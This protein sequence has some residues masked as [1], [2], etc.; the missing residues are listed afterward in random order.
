MNSPIDDIAFLARSE[1]RVRILRAIDECPRDRRA[2]ATVTDT[3]KS[4]LSRTLGELE[5]QGWIER[6]GQ[7]YELTTA[8]TLVI[9]QFV[10]L[11]NTVSV[12]QKL[13]GAVDL[14]P[15]DETDLTVQHLADAQFVTPTELNPTAPFDYGIERL[16]KADHFRCVA[17]TAPPRYVQAIH[18][19]VV[20]ERLTA[21]CVLDGTY[22]EDLRDEP[23]LKRRWSEITLESGT[24]RRSE[25]SIPFVLLVLDDTVHLWLCD[26]GGESQVLVESENPD[27]LSWANTTVDRY[28]EQTQLIEPVKVDSRS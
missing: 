19:G 14:L 3:P 22:L 25:E 4:T 21:E 28:L 24:V 13:D 18:E 27:V 7:L 11:L 8:G 20:S 23:N 2:L 26:E 17:R 5:D 16:R 6:N 15:L 12:L 9:E 10:P 1:T